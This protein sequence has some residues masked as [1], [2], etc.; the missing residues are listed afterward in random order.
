MRS[1]IAPQHLPAEHAERR[2]APTASRRRSARK[3]RGRCRAR[4]DGSA[5]S[6]WSRSTGTRRWRASRTPRSAASRARAAS[7]PPRRRRRPRCAFP[8]ASLRKISASGTIT[9]AANTAVGHHR[10]APSEIGDRALEDRRPDRAGEIEPAREQRE[11]RAAAAVEPAADID[12]ERR[13][14]AG[15]AEQADEQAVAE[16]ELPELAEASRSRARCR[17]TRRRRSPSCG[18]RSGRRAVPS[19]GRRRNCRTRPASLRATAPSARRRGRRRSSSGRPPRSTARR[20]QPRSSTSDTVATTQEVR[21]SMLG[22]RQCQVPAVMPPREPRQ[23]AL[24]GEGAKSIAARHGIARR[25][26]R[27]PALRASALQ[28]RLELLHRAGCRARTRSRGR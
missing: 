6:T 22:M 24:A 4:P 28:A 14:E 12:I 21:V 18:R 8:A 2:A 1:A 5:A 15:G 16:I 7:R 9:A 23:A 27:S 10:G 11:R 3:S 20:T 25:C 17:S 13:V 26:A 19:S